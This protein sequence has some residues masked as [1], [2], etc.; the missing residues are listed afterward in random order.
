M[1]YVTA[2]RQN[3]PTTTAATTT[4]AALTTTTLNQQ[5]ST[6]DSDSTT[7][8]NQATTVTAL[9]TPT[10]IPRP[11]FVIEPCDGKIKSQFVFAEI[12]SDNDFC[13]ILDWWFF[14]RI[15]LFRKIFLGGEISLRVSLRSV[16]NVRQLNSLK[17]CSTV[18]VSYA[19]C[20]KVL[21]SKKFSEIWFE[22]KIEKIS[23]WM[24]K[25]LNHN[26]PLFVL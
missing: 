5:T 20:C 12:S 22:W 8:T 1:T 14:F 25:S 3:A 23:K 15:C 13:N 6:T 2:T 24:K 4:Q 9:Q 19:Y 16:D 18:S 11:A 26:G 7:L 17:R 21:W 10:G